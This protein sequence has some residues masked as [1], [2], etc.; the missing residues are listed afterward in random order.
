[1]ELLRQYALI[2]LVFG[3]IYLALTD[4]EA[5]AYGNIRATISQQP[6]RLPHAAGRTLH[7]LGFI[8]A[9]VGCSLVAFARYLCKPSSS[10]YTELPLEDNSSD[11]STSPR[12]PVSPSLSHVQIPQPSLRKMR[13]FFLLLVLTICIRA[14][15]FR[16]LVHSP[17]CVGLAYQEFIPFILA[18]LD[19]WL[20]QRHKVS[21]PEDTSNLSVYE[22]VEEYWATSRFRYLVPTAV[23]SLASAV[24]L[25]HS[26]GL[27][28]TIICPPSNY[29]TM[30]LI[31]RL[32]LFLD[33]SVVFCSDYLIRSYAS[34]PKSSP[35]KSLTIIG[36][37][38]LSSASAI[39]VWGIIWFLAVPEDRFWVLEIP[40]GFVWRLIKLTVICCIAALSACI[41]VSI[42][43]SRSWQDLNLN[44]DHRRYSTRAHCP[45]YLFSLLS[46]HVRSLSVGRGIPYMPFLQTQT[47]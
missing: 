17:Q 30:K 29:D 34:S 45:P 16:R 26:T 6:C 14:E 23:L 21:G 28:S 31:Q 36:W 24:V 7:V 27:S 2:G 44:T 47:L 33:F 9:S 13:V 35:A 37:A 15:A 19:F 46:R 10:A 20:Y 12:S 40:R 8:L 32:A 42:H 39:G 38:C 22:L 3:T 1:M 11:G 5:L 4:A 18:I 43:S 25:Q 41:T